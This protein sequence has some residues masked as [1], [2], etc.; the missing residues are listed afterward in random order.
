MRL[1]RPRPGPRPSG[2]RRVTES[3]SPDHRPDATRSDR[4]GRPPPG[5]RLA[6]GLAAPPPPTAF[7]YSRAEIPELRWTARAAVE[8]AIG[9]PTGANLFRITVDPLE[10]R[11]AAPPGGAPARVAGSL[12]DTLAVPGVGGA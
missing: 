4:A 11:I 8:A 3:A 2:V 5:R 1:P 12:P 9:I 10:D 6:P 7:T